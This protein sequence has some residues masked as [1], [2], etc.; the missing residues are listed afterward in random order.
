MTDVDLLVK[1]ALEQRARSSARKRIELTLGISP[2]R[3]SRPF[4]TLWHRY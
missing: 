4:I 3:P 1:E 2:Y